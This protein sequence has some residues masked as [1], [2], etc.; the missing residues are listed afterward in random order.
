VQSFRESGQIWH[1]FEQLLFLAAIKYP[2][3]NPT[4]NRYGRLLIRLLGHEFLR[5]QIGRTED[6]RALYQNLE[7]VL[8]K[9]FHYW[10]QRGSYELESGDLTLADA[11]LK[12]SESLVEGEDIKLETAE[13]YLLLKRACSSPQ[14]VASAR[15]A[16]EGI[17]RLEAILAKE[18]KASPHTYHVFA[19]Q[20]LL[21]IEKAKIRGTER[22]DLLV[23]LWR[24]LEKTAYL[25]PHN[26]I[27]EKARSA[28]LRARALS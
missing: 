20:G 17:R 8:G 5:K 9:E 23:R 4:R 25:F 21:W 10:L 24:H 16:N 11:Y 13:C 14:S 1:L 6:I 19:V 7:E 27:L 3:N 22:N 12:Q 26:E 18:P 2:K 28:V 15:D